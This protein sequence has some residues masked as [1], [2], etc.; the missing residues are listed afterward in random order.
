MVQ[1]YAQKDSESP[2]GRYSSRTSVGC[3]PFRMSA[4]RTDASSWPAAD[5]TATGSVSGVIAP[6]FIRCDTDLRGASTEQRSSYCSKGLGLSG[7]TS[8]GRETGG[9]ML[10]IS[11]LN[12]FYYIRN[13]TDMRCKHARIL[14]VIREQLHREPS[15]SDVFIVLSKDRRTVRLFSYDECSCTFFEKKFTPEYQFMRIVTDK[16]GNEI[17]YHIDWRDVVL[18][19]ENPVVKTLII[20]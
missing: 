20:R 3:G 12:R 13:F 11:G 17:A 8:A 19:L 10:N 15:K 16:E 18:L 2:D 6:F 9:S 5:G 14:S 1:G 7:F 4:G